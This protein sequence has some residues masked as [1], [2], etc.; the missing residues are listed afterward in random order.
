M[1]SWLS[2]ELCSCMMGIV[3]QGITMKSKEESDSKGGGKASD[4]S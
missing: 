4:V 1:A 2:L 3:V